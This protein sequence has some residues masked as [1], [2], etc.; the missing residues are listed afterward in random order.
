MVVKPSYESA[1]RS[2]LLLFSSFSPSTGLG[3]Y[4][5]VRGD[6][7]RAG[8]Y[9]KLSFTALCRALGYTKWFTIV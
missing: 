9:S 5:V 3:V 8:R 4:F 1:N 7:R 6:P 2:L